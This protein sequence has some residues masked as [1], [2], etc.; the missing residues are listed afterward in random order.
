MKYG[1]DRRNPDP[2]KF[3]WRGFV[4]GLVFGFVLARYLVWVLR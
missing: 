1:L 3:P 2:P 4:F